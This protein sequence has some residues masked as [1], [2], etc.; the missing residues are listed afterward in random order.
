MRNEIPLG[1]FV[2]KNKPTESIE[3]LFYSPFL[4]GANNVIGNYLFS[5]WY[6]QSR[7]GRSSAPHAAAVNAEP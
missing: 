6:Y 2:G 3:K 1:F 7:A 5:I 4:D